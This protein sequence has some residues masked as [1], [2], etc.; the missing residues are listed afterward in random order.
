MTEAKHKT[1]FV[2]AGGGSLGAVHVGM[3][4]ALLAAD[5]RPDFVIGASV[6]AINAAYFAGAPTVEGV[7]KLEQIWCELRRADLFPLTLTNALGLLRHPAN[8][9]DPAPLRRLIEN[10]LPYSRLEEALIPIH[11]ATTDVQGI[12]TLLSRGAAVDAILASA[13]IPGVFPP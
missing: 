3:L 6:G 11:V 2:F 13:A 7:A 12:A 10:N 5:E 8:I 4:R 9:V 1:A